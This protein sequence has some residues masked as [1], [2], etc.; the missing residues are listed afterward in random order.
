MLACRFTAALPLLREWAIEC[1]L[2]D[3]RRLG[4]LIVPQQKMISARRLAFTV[5]EVL[6]VVA[7]LAIVMSILLP[8]FT[9]AKA[10]G[11]RVLCA[12]NEHNWGAGLRSYANDNRG[13]FPDNRYSTSA[14]QAA[15]NAAYP[16][17]YTPGY[18]TS[19]N[20][21]VV[22]KFWKNY[23]VQNNSTAKTDV[24]DV[25]N[26]PSQR[27]HQ[28]NDV[29]LAGGLVGYFYLPG[30]S[31]DNG[32]NY[33]IA[34]N[35]WVFKDKFGGPDSKAP[36]MMDQKQYSVSKGMTGGGWWHDARVPYSSHPRRTGEPE[37]GNFLFEDVH[38][39]WYDSDV[40][41]NPAVDDPNDII[42]Q[43]GTLGDW[44]YLYKIPIN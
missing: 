29:N 19:W 21:S 27:W 41:E 3:P 1:R 44:W 13:Y 35:G 7:I 18:H 33:T 30:R 36:I 11:T 24:H 9:K 4:V 32:S 28:I 8:S 25:L 14:T 20:S 5:P 10:Y 39:T 43:S 15:F 40:G 31:Q 17:V 6:A 22:Q 42:K 38:V 16:P 12:T 2:V 34:G 23:L 37:G 26:C